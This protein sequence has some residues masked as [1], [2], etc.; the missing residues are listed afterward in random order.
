MVA[1]LLLLAMGSYMPW[2]GLLCEYL[3]GFNKFRGTSKFV[4]QATLFVILL[5][6]M[7]LDCLIRD[8]LRKRWQ[9]LSALA[10]AASLSLILGLAI[11]QSSLSPSGFWPG[12]VN[13]LFSTGQVYLTAGAIPNSLIVMKA[14][15]F[16]SLGLAVL[17]GTCILIA[18]IL[19]LR[20]SNLWKASL[21]VGLAVVELFCADLP[22]RETFQLEAAYPTG[23]V[24]SF[25]WTPGDQRILNPFMPNL[26]MSMGWR[27]VWG[28][29][30]LV[31]RRYGEFM[32]WM[33]KVEITQVIQNVVQ[34]QTHP[35]LSMLGCRTALM[36]VGDRVELTELRGD[37]MPRAVLVG[38][39]AVEPDRDRAFAILGEPGF[40]PRRLVVLEREPNLAMA[41]DVSNPG[42]VKVT[43]TST[44]HLTFEADVN[45]A[46]ILVVTDSFTEG[47]RIVP[48]AGSA[49]GSYEIIPADYTLRGVPLAPGRHHF[50]MEYRPAS[51]VIGVWFSLAG[52]AAW[53]ALAGFLVRRKRNPDAESRKFSLQKP[54]KQRTDGLPIA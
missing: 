30:P 38:R 45:S 5:S 31:P 25:R 49:S 12:I 47:W 3:P 29:D 24:E 43:E 7:G 50:R 44:D 13:W 39:W 17:A 19:F 11:R 33:Q 32:A 10:A 4:F 34:F 21:L 41:E 53:L 36:P 27:D 22:A 48:L 52:C 40:N 9:V 6:A 20:I 23:M 14:G 15:T 2:F 42:T 37:P 51:F 46:S 16:A 8:G 26:A 18:A 28:H 54:S 1:I 35:L